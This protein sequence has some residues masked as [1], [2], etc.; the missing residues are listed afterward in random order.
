MSCCLFLFTVQQM[1]STSLPSSPLP[2][3][4]HLH[5]SSTD[6]ILASQS[7]SWSN[8]NATPPTSLLSCSTPSSPSS[9]PSSLSSCSSNALNSPS[10]NQMPPAAWRCWYGCGKEYKK[11]SGRSI[12]RHVT[13]C[14]RQH[15]PGGET[16][17][18]EQV[19][20]LI[21]SQQESGQLQTGDRQEFRAREDS[22]SEDG[23]THSGWRT[24]C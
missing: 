23:S 14:F 9:S 2:Q 19:S 4:P 6:F 10:S 3:P 11:S 8:D 7:S 20:A 21:S 18:E 17:T 12:R 24:R 16:L 22:Q 13:C 1:S 5:R 15:W